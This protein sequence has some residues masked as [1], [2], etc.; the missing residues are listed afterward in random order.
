MVNT[1]LEMLFSS[2]LVFD[3]ADLISV[4]CFQEPA[5][6]KSEVIELVAKAFKNA[7]ISV[8]HPFTPRSIELDHMKDLSHLLCILSASVLSDKSPD[9][10]M[11]LTTQVYNSGQ[12]YLSA[13]KLQQ[14]ASKQEALPKILAVSCLC[15]LPAAIKTK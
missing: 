12:H 11:R 1:A 14:Q 15:D 3:A 5:D 10:G 8:K 4:L 6:S 2:K 9:R 7:A 13:I